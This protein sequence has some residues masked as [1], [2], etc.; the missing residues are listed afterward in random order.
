[1]I[2]LKYN[3]DEEKCEYIFNID[4]MKKYMF[5]LDIKRLNSISSNIYFC[6]YQPFKCCMRYLNITNTI[7]ISY[8]NMFDKTGVETGS[9]YINPEN[10][11]EILQGI[12]KINNTFKQYKI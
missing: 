8:D 5:V 1:M 9:F 7:I 6:H 12:E 3:K 11:E 2:K 10:V 4:M